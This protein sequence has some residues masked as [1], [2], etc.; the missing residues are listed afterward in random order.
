M[1]SVSVWVTKECPSALSC[2][3]S[4]R[5]FSMMPL[6]TTATRA[7]AWGWAFTVVAAPWVAQRVCPMPTE[8]AMGACSST[9][10]SSES[11]PVARRRSSRPSST[12]AIPALS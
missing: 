6:C 5:K 3:R 2:S 11:L 10:A 12:V 4:S 7:E 1:V 9:L 8:P